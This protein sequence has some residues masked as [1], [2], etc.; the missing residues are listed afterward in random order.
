MY[1]LFTHSS[2][3]QSLYSATLLPAL[4]NIHSFTVLVAAL[5]LIN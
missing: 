1:T 5:S 3:F 4:L 2:I